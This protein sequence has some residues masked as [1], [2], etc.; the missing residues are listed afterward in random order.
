MKI[1]TGEFKENTIYIVVWIVLF[2]TPVITM[3][4]RVNSMT[5]IV[6]NWFEILNVWK[7]FA[8]FLLLFI[9][10]NF[11]IAPQLVYHG[12][13]V[14]YF[15]LLVCLILSFFVYECSDHPQM[16]PA[17]RREHYEM[18]QN[19]R[20]HQD[21][22]APPE[23]RG[24]DLWENKTIKPRLKPRD[25]GRGAPLFMGQMEIINSLIAILMIGMNLGVKFYF[26]SEDYAKEVKDLEQKNL[27]QQLEYLKY[28]INPHFFMNTLNN[29]HALV[30]IDPK[31][32]QASI[33]ILSKLMRYVLYE[34]NKGFV[35]LELEIQFV[36]NY[37]A[38]M[39]LRYTDKVEINMNI[40]KDIPDKLV[41]PLVL[42]TFIENAFKHGIS[43]LRTSFVDVDVSFTNEWLHF[44]C[45]NSRVKNESKE[46]KGG[47]GLINVQKRLQ[48]LYDKDYSLTFNEGKD[49][50][51]VQLDFP[52]KNFA[53][54]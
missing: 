40:P 44:S 49:T 27:E 39:R 7:V 4:V 53:Q 18:G 50:Y 16:D 3:F 52:L 17:H 26:K 6:F 13:K 47:M 21:G 9:I 23:F 11:V 36:K 46:N 42:I 41:P 24:T 51:L 34:G 32:A 14:R 30:D 33:V 22:S 12:K 15:V 28:Q 45:E 31:C 25:D 19:G 48:L 35:P 20:M 8:L 5:N 38:L 43:Y 1:H 54:T 2:L 29:I 37:V 10:H